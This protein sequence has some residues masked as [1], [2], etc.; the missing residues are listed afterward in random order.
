MRVLG[1]CS[2]GG[3]GHLNPMVPLLDALAA[4]GDEVAVVAPP[5]LHEMVTRTGHRFLAGGEP[6]EEAI[7]P[8]RDQLVSLPARQASVLGNR[9][10]FGRLAARAMQPGV[11]R[12]FDLFAPD[13][14]LREPCEYAAAAEA[15]GRGLA[16][17]QVA[18]TVAE[19][20]ERSLE[21]AA[22]ALEELR[23]G[24]TDELRR[25]P[26]LS[27]FPASLDPSPFPATHRYREPAGTAGSPLPDWWGG[28]GAPL[29]YATFGTVM[30]RMTAA[31][32]IYRTAVNALGRL[33]ARVLL[34]VGPSFD[35]GL[36]DPLPANVHVEAWLDQD[37]VLAHARAV[38][39]HGGSGTV[40]GALAAGVPVVAVP[41]FADQFE[42][43]RRLAAAG[44]GLEVR[45]PVGGPGGG[46][47]PVGAAQVAELSAAV[48][49]VLDEPS[50]AERAAAVSAE[51]A[52]APGVATLMDEVAPGP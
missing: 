3:A 33:D 38:L 35:A 42:N 1:A 4:R 9:E 17:L 51:M 37:L 11:A 41:S 32:G 50:F 10:L 39:C 6:P 21:D 49:R 20:E 13:L 22:P 8:L 24:L 2:L 5:A 28:S 48:A 19:G 45:N 25:A 29:V 40:L 12:A 36:L 27:R 31:A 16:Q 30:G 23:P 52:A 44:A 34:T 26:Y 46:R 43:A 14:V 15:A 47:R 7:A 18:I